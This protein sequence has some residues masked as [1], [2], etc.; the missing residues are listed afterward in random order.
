MLRMLLLLP[1]ILVALFFCN[2]M[3][4]A[5]KEHEKGCLMPFAGEADEGHVCNEKL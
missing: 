3:N 2:I 5:Q 1:F 4:I